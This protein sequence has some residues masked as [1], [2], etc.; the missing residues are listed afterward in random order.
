MKNLKFRIK[1]NCLNEEELRLYKKKLADVSHQSA[2]IK[3]Y[4]Q[5]LFTVFVVIFAS[6]LINAQSVDSL[7]NEAIANNPN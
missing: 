3:Y 5:Y 2:K 7:V 6:I 4:C 1:N